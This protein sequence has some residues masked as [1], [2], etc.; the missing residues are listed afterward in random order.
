MPVVTRLHVGTGME[1]LSTTYIIANCRP[2]ASIH[3]QLARSTP[4]SVLATHSCGGQWLVS[5]CCNPVYTA[6]CAPSQVSP[7]R[8][9]LTL[10]FFSEGC[11]L[12]DG[13]LFSAA[14]KEQLS[15]KICCTLIGRNVELTSSASF[16]YSSSILAAT[17][18]V[19]L[20]C[21]S[22]Y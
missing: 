15:C 1:Y 22:F 18:H 19:Q 12:P 13:D 16:S 11:G 4:S 9:R 8:C 17:K 7:H 6:V 2:H 5:M 20:R 21:L 3:V 10:F 14:T